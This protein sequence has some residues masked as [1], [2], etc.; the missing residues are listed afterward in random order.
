MTEIDDSIAI[1]GEVVKGDLSNPARNRSRSIRMNAGLC[2]DCGLVEFVEGYKVC[3]PCRLKR[4]ATDKAFKKA[5]VL[6]GVCVRCGK[7]KDRLQTMCQV[8]AD[9]QIAQMRILRKRNKEYIVAHFGGKC[10]ECSQADIRCLSLDH[11]DNNG[12]ID[13]KGGNGK[14]ITSTAWYSKLRQAIIKNKLS[15]IRLQLLCF[16]C[17]AKKDLAPWWFHDS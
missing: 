12:N 4:L 1:Y 8:C 14:R 7:E 5:R 3:E 2:R 13:C 6:L 9:A 11:V 17:H 10:V 15:E 16:N